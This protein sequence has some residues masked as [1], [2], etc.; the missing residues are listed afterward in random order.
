V[1]G[2][3]KG[4]IGRLTLEWMVEAATLPAFP[5]HAASLTLDSCCMTFF[6]L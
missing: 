4:L 1:Q 2:R 6:T 3:H 5:F